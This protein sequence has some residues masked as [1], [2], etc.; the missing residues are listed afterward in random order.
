ML[1]ALL[2]TRSRRITSVLDERSAALLASR[3]EA[4]AAH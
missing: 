3:I 4:E 2:S 1:Y